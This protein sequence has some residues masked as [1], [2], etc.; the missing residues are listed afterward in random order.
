MKCISTNI[1]RLSLNTY[2]F[3][4]PIYKSCMKNDNE[5]KRNQSLAL[6][7]HF[8]N[9]NNANTEKIVILY[10]PINYNYI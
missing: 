1:Y 6:V 5:I 8:L 4:V 9:K 10:L 7:M 3:L 2:I